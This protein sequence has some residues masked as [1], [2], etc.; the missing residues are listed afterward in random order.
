MG[1]GE[2]LDFPSFVL[3]LRPS[4]VVFVVV[5]ATDSEIGRGKFIMIM[6][7]VVSCR[8]EFVLRGFLSNGSKHNHSKRVWAKMEIF[9]IIY[10]RYMVT[11]DSQ[12]GA[13]HTI[14]INIGTF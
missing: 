4:F 3:L 6:R 1:R 11:R 2:K 9:S 10:E 7:N 13:T 5:E 12:T 14:A 8:F